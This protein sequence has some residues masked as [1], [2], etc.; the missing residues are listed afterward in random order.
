M[1]PFIHR[2][3][4]SMGMGR[5]RRRPSTGS[6]LDQ[7]KAGIAP[8]PAGFRDLEAWLIGFSRAADAGKQ[9]GTSKPSNAVSL[10]VEPE[11]VLALRQALAPARGIKAAFVHGSI[12]KGEQTPGSEIELIVIVDPT[13]A[14]SFGGLHEAEKLLQR[15]IRANFVREQEWRRELL[16][17]GAYL[18][19]INAEPRI[20]IFA[21][22]DDLLG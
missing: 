22:A 21:S 20:V 9:N 14:G 6:P 2:E 19:K 15:P 17:G 12:A 8:L 13:F 1:T 18:T 3:D 5:T 11:L 16:R 4:A 10:Q 7:T